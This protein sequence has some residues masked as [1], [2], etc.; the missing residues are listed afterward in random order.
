MKTAEELKRQLSTLEGWMPF[1]E[2]KFWYST[3]KTWLPFYVKSY[4]KKIAK[5]NLDLF[6]KERQCGVARHIPLREVV[7]DNFHYVIAAFTTKGEL[8]EETIHE[9]KSRV[10]EV[11][12]D[13]IRYESHGIG[14]FYSVIHEDG[15][16]IYDNYQITEVVTD[17]PD[18]YIHVFATAD[19][20]ELDCPYVAW[21]HSEGV[22]FKYLLDANY[23]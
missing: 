16:P 18:V 12:I 1:S 20:S 13:V 21:A 4:K 19:V 9:L 2:Q 7:Y 17:M 23:L 6:T 14:G 11:P 22:I 5:E 15:R 8:N 3:I 10:A